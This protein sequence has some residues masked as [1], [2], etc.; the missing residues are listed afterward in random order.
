[1]ANDG[2]PEPS[3]DPIFESAEPLFEAVKKYS[4]ARDVSQV[5]RFLATHEENQVTIELLYSGGFDGKAWGVRVVDKDGYVAT[6]DPS[7]DFR[8]ALASIRWDE[9]KRPS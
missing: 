4:G 1:M 9:L 8:K 7:H 3:K 6:G 5:F 2:M